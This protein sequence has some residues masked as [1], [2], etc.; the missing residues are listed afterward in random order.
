[1]KDFS[2]WPCLLTD[3]D[4][5]RWYFL[6][7]MLTMMSI[8]LS[9]AGHRVALLVGAVIDG[10]VAVM[11]LSTWNLA[12]SMLAVF[13]LAIFGTSVYRVCPWSQRAVWFGSGLG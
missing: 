12:F 13:H 8:L 7:M 3:A 9:C 10:I 6:L 2:G 11:I 5:R 1:M 4:D